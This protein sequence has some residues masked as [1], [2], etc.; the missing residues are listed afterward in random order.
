MWVVV[1]T[2]L[3][4][5]MDVKYLES[6]LTRGPS[7]G[8]RGATSDKSRSV[9]TSAPTCQ[10]PNILVLRNPAESGRTSVVA[11]DELMYEGRP[12]PSRSARCAVTVVGPVPQIQQPMS[13]ERKTQVS[14]HNDG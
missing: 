4:S 14:I 1:C 9:P 8:W 13:T 11:H 12:L 2:V 3:A 6:A 10:W 5:R 7:R